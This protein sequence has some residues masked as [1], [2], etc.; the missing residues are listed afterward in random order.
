MSVRRTDRCII[1][2]DGKMKMPVIRLAVSMANDF[3]RDISAIA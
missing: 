1:D 3:K 2:L